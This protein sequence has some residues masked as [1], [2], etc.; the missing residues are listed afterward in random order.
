M[1]LNFTSF[2]LYFINT[3]YGTTDKTVS[4]AHKYGRE[5][6]FSLSL[7][8]SSPPPKHSR[9]ERANQSKGIAGHCQVTTTPVTRFHVIFL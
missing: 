1:P 6:T 2:G 4:Q 5:F 7:I 3:S 9:Q 8:K